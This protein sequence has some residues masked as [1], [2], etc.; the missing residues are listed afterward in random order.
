MYDT[1]R[2]CTC[3]AEASRAAE[4][5]PACRKEWDSME[6]GVAAPT[7]GGRPKLPSPEHDDDE[8]A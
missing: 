3:A 4:S 8:A 2:D 6:G 5:S 7:R 1:T